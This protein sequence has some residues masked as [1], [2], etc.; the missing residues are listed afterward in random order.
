MQ[1]RNPLVAEMPFVTAVPLNLRVSTRVGSRR[2]FRHE[3]FSQGEFVFVQTTQFVS[4]RRFAF[5]RK[6]SFVL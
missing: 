3:S 1:G 5:S 2:K 6:A 4:A